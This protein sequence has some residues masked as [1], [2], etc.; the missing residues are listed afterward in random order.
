MLGAV[1]LNVKSQSRLPKRYFSGNVR[2][3][4]FNGCWSFGNFGYSKGGVNGI[5]SSL[6]GVGNFSDFLGMPYCEIKPR[7]AI[8]LD[9][10]G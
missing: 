10:Y 2:S 6:E 9:F 4:G 5:A 7:R 3:F 1:L 8:G